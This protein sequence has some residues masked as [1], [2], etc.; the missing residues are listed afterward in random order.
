MPESTKSRHKSKSQKIAKPYPKFPLTAHPTGRWCKKRRGKQHYFGPLADW[1]GALE[2][3]QREWPYI[4]N[5]RIPPP[6]D[7]G[8]GCA[9]RDLCNAFLIAKQN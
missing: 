1:Q 6:V 7:N 4:I 3:Y 2:R 8:E 9:I 5:G